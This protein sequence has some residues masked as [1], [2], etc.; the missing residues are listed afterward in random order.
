MIEQ[1][2]PTRRSRL[3][4]D[5]DGEGGQRVLLIENRD[6]RCEVKDVCPAQG[7]AEVGKTVP[8]G[9][10]RASPHGLGNSFHDVRPERVR[11]R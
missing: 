1:S 9:D 8:R 2:N 3:M 5:E 6:Q 7:I 11:L 4:G 10:L